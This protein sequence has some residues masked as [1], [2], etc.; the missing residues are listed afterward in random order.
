MHNPGEDRRVSEVKPA[1]FFDRDGVLNVEKNYLH[2]SEDFAWQPEAP[3]AIAWLKSQG[4][5][6]IVVTNQSGIA[7]GYYEETD[8]H[9]LHDHMQVLLQ[10]HNAAI[11]AFYYCPHL[12]NGKVAVYAKEC[13]CRKPGPGMIE[14]A[15]AEYAIDRSRSFLVGDKVSDVQAAEAAGIHGCL[16]EG[17]SLLAFVRNVIKKAE[18]A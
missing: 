5:L 18:S 10:K 11:D 9:A 16:Y 1:V 8:M 12:P 17:G 14:Q 3:E 13:R 15:L 2:K 6:V 7:R 4:Y